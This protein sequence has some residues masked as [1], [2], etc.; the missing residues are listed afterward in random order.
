M[1]WKIKKWLLLLIIAMILVGMTSCGSKKAGI[2]LTSIAM[3]ESQM[4]NMQYTANR[5]IT[6]DEAKIKISISQ[7]NG[8]VAGTVYCFSE[9][10]EGLKKGQRYIALFDMA[11]KH[12]WLVEGSLS[13]GGTRV[14]KEV[15]TENILSL[16][17]SDATVTVFFLIGDET[18]S[19]MTLEND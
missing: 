4:L 10:K 11:A 3:S 5:H 13:L 14:M 18:V 12:T 1:M 8:K 7:E 2:E 16:M 6:A 15:N 17:G 19:E 9:L